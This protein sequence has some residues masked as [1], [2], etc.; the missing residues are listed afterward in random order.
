MKNNKYLAHGLF[1]LIYIGSTISS[2]IK[3]DSERGL[4]GDLFMALVISVIAS[5]AYN[6]QLKKRDGFMAWLMAFGWPFILT[7]Y[8]IYYIY[9][10]PAKFV[11]RIFGSKNSGSSSGSAPK[12]SLAKTMVD[13]NIERREGKIKDLKAQ[14]KHYEEKYK[15]EA[16]LPYGSRSLSLEVIEARIKDIKYEIDHNEDWRDFDIKQQKYRD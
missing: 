6:W 12:S 16:S 8:M 7:Y 3:G 5:F 11:L 9:I 14:L 13:G 10:V 1:Y 15:F 4:G 2:H